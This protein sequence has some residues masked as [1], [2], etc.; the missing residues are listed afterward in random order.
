MNIITN[1]IKTFVF[2]LE[3][4]MIGGVQKFTLQMYLFSKLLILKR[5]AVL[6]ISLAANTLNYDVK[7]YLEKLSVLKINGVEYFRSV[8]FPTIFIFRV[9]ETG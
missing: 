7:R 9:D 1:M 4:F 3:V 6:N 2:T 8:S 5:G